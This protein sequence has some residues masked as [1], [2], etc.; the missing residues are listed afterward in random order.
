[1]CGFETWS[2][3]LREEHRPMVFEEDNLLR[4]IVVLCI[5]GK[6]KRRLEKTDFTNEQLHDFFLNNQ[7]DALI[8]PILFCY[9]TLHVSG[10]FSAHHHGDLLM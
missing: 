5:R 2:F 10:I 6:D 4:K 3:T 9:K 7:P 8:I 1:V